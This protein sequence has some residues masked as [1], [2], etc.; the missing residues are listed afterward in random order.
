MH[1]ADLVDRY[2]RRKRRITLC[3]DLQTARQRADAIAMLRDRTDSD[4]AVSSPSPPAHGRA[5]RLSAPFTLRHSPCA[6]AAAAA[7]L[8]RVGKWRGHRRAEPPRAQ[9]VAQGSPRHHADAR[10]LGGQEV[11]RPC[12]LCEHARTAILTSSDQSAP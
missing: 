1:T 5:P 9:A 4:G 11:C 12:L 6:H 3:T 7:F 8:L 2:K 10:V